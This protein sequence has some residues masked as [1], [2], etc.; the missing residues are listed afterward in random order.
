MA[1]HAGRVKGS[2]KGN[3][4]TAPLEDGNYIARVVQ[5]ID[6]GLQAQRPYQGEEKAPA[7]EIMLT[8]EFGT[9]F[10]KDDDGKDMEDKPRWL[11]ETFP[12][13]SYKADLAKSTKRAKAIKP[14]ANGDFADML[15]APCTVT[16]VTRKGTGQH[17]GKTFENVGAVTPAMKG[18]PVPEL[19]NPTKMFDLDNPDLNVFEELPEWLQDKIKGNLEFGGSKLEA[20]LGG[21]PVPQKQEPQA[22]EEPDTEEPW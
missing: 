4:K 11:S 1:L 10:L 5:V 20:L 6:L 18:M 19:V 13:R 15:G 7:H 3:T 22:T 9:E 8:Y 14:S 16:V 12:L 17:A 21:E 2:S